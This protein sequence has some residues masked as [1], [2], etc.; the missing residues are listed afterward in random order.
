MQYLTNR[1][2]SIDTITSGLN[3][4]EVV[5]HELDKSMFIYV[6]ICVYI[7]FYIYNVIHYYLHE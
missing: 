5:I 4:I 2:E 6:S 1:Q 3:Q 7:C